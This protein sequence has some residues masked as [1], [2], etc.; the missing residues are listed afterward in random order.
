MRIVHIT[1]Y[2]GG[3]GGVETYTKSIAEAARDKGN[4]VTIICASEKNVRK[5]KT[6][7]GIKIIYLPEITRIMNAPI[8]K[9]IVTELA[10]IKPDI[11]H[12]HIPNPWG[13]VNAFLYK[14]VNPKV[15][16]IATYHSDVVGYS[17]LMKTL[18][19]L[20]TLYLVPSLSLFC[21]RVIAT[22]DN[23]ISGSL[24]L[25]MV[26]K[27]VV[28]IPLGVDTSKF[29]PAQ[30]SGGKFCFLFVGRLIPYKGL[31]YLIK[32]AGILKLSD[33]K[34]TIKIVG[35]GKLRKNLE[36][37]ARLLNVSDVVKFTGSVGNK[38]LPG[39]YRNCDA[40]VL[41][42]VYKTEAF[43]ISQLEAM[44]SGKPVISTNIRGSGVS[45]VNKDGV[46]GFVVR[47]KDEIAL[48][49]AM[50]KLFDNKKLRIFMGKNARKRAV[51]VFDGKIAATRTL[52]IYDS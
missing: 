29:S 21:S 7:N 16:I 19:F 49:N 3:I 31:E 23:Y 14:I 47:P 11:I 52:R 17:L 38:D 2:F 41:P 12:L 27:K 48:A 34:F 32:A 36:K 8:T 4:E 22:S 25:R 30:K 43:G 44:A 9:Q 42:S 5:E 10:R 1:K 46:T 51:K 40:F 24:A 39:V 6:E 45:F 20:R 26:G 33:K 37:L 35:D 13:E 18:S 28:V 50:M 15:K